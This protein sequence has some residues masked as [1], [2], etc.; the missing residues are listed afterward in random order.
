MQEIAQGEYSYKIIE[1]MAS[2]SNRD[3]NF[4]L[5]IYGQHL[6]DA[7]ISLFRS[8]HGIMRRIMHRNGWILPAV[9]KV[10]SVYEEVPRENL[11]HSRNHR[12]QFIRPRGVG[13][14]LLYPAK[15]HITSVLSQRIDLSNPIT[16]GGKY[17]LET[18]EFFSGS[19]F[20]SV[21]SVT[22]DGLSDDDVAS[23]AGSTTS[24]QKEKKEDRSK[25]EQKELLGN[26]GKGRKIPVRLR[27]VTGNSRMDDY[28]P[29]APAGP[30]A[31]PKVP[32][33]G[34]RVAD[35]EPEDK[36]EGFEGAQGARVQ[37]RGQVKKIRKEEQNREARYQMERDEAYRILVEKRL[38]DF[39][40]GK[41][42]TDAVPAR[43]DYNFPG[44]NSDD[45]TDQIETDT[46]APTRVD[47]GSESDSD[48]EISIASAPVPK[49]SKGQRKAAE[50]AKKALR[51]AES[52]NLP[53]SKKKK[54]GRQTAN[55]N[56]E[57]G[58]NSNLTAREKLEQEQML[59]YRHNLEMQEK[60]Q[61]DA[62]LLHIQEEMLLQQLEQ[63]REHYPGPI[64]TNSVD[65]YYVPADPT[66]ESTRPNVRPATRPL[67]HR[68]FPS[69]GPMFTQSRRYTSTQ[70][71]P[72][73]IH[74]RPPR[75]SH[76]SPSTYPYPGPIH[77]NSVD[78]YYIPS[79][80]RVRVSQDID[81]EVE[82]RR[83]KYEELVRAAANRRGAANVDYWMLDEDDMDFGTAP[84]ELVRE[85]VDRQDA[86]FWMLD[87]GEMDFRTAP[88]PRQTK[89]T[90]A[91]P[92]RQTKH[93]PARR[94]RR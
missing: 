85:A 13:I 32:G 83:I 50:R 54:N 16:L 57:A 30:N 52:D 20:D 66:I 61:R 79:E 22:D 68:G 63:L 65:P 69:P 29:A 27:P 77:T 42:E 51:E 8:V 74:V 75:H 76:V 14:P 35:V 31:P 58:K 40:E 6:I 49:M 21:L 10:P 4:A 5:K 78:P 17:C 2:Q 39:A 81:D 86:D 38:Q 7:K 36:K 33:S 93:K 1:V 64:H 71:P 28:G 23:E 82:A 43:S 90:T 18:A 60:K 67:H 41:E 56:V 47:E 24:S 62:R 12:R 53:A 87:D 44:G 48:G 72:R 19:D 91:P 45:R 25:K 46:F 26:K 15:S 11:A 3:D 89:H 80:Q 88:P 84:P 55:Q 34:R 94:A 73:H 9:V 70:N 59:L 37:S 92:P